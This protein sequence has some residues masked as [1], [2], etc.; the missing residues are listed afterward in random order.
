MNLLGKF[1]LI[2]FLPSFFLFGFLKS[3]T[4]F[5]CFFESLSVY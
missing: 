4:I 3:F 5:L 2:V 1:F